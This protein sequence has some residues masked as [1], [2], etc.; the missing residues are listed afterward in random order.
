MNFLKFKNQFKKRML[1]FCMLV[2]LFGSS[3]GLIFGIQFFAWTKMTQ[4]FLQKDT[5]RVAL[6][7][8]FDGKHPCQICKH[9]QSKKLIRITERSSPANFKNAKT[10]I[11]SGLTIFG[12]ITEFQI[13]SFFHSQVV[14]YP[15]KVLIQS[16]HPK[17]LTP[18]PEQNLK[19]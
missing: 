1:A 13:K 15:L 2:S 7:K 5:A 19:A 17:P 6:K 12:V 8:T 11:S 3:G 14:Y 18:P 9:L 16:L 10:L 4:K